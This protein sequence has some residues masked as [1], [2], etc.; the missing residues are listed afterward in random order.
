MQEFT[1]TI[2]ISADGETVEG[3][4]TGMQGKGCSNVAALLDRVGQELEHR[5][6]DDYDQAEPVQIGATG[7][8][9]LWQG[10]R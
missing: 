10:G 2:N 5:H 1:L 3:T 4:V 8:R 7:S 6:T 9:R